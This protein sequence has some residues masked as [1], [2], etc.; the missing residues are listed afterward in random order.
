MS[1]DP[2]IILSILLVISVVL[3]VFRPGGLLAYFLPSICWAA[4][5]LVTLSLSGL[6]TIRSWTNKRIIKMALLAAIFQIFILIDAGLI[7][8]F[9]K[10]PV[11]FTTR[12]ITMNLTLVTT[13]LLGTELSRAYL[14]K[15]LNKKKP[16]LT[17]AFITLLYTLI[18]VSIFALLEFKDPLAYSKFIGTGFLP[19]LTENLLATYLALLSG[20]TA[21]LAYLTPLRSFKWFTPILPDLSWGFEA[22]LGVMIPTIGFVA[23]TQV[24]SQGDLIRIGV[25][26]RSKKTVCPT[27][28]SKSS[29]RGW[30]V[31]SAL[32]VLI[33]WTSTGLL[34]FY[35]SVI[36]SGSMRPTMDVG[37]LAIVVSVDPS[38]IQ[39]GDIIQFWNGEEMILHRVVAITGEQ[40][41]FRT[42]GD[43][44]LSPDPN[45]VLPNQIRGKM[46]FNVP[47]IG[48]AS[49]YTKTAIASVWSFFS[50]NTALLYSTLFT[51][52]LISSFHIIR[53]HKKH[54]HNY[55]R[56]KRGW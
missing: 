34:G 38:K 13:T 1:R 14:A 32:C 42:K 26:P 47:K 30:F 28:N 54:S 11:S 44:N 43:D 31:I 56:R 39:V 6:D 3:N 40:R 55:W 41:T 19:V 21:S 27:R 33:V 45:P 2:I 16:T 49:I 5:A 7:T 29:E 25:S 4:I 9:G 18:N 46:A 35:P 20:P 53:A 23:I 12:A 22:L 48:W 24:T 17:L 50:A 37:D 8:G 36:G 52:T 15:N 51:I 10:S